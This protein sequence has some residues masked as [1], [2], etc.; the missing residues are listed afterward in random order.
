MG[1]TKL[2]MTPAEEARAIELM[3]Y[4][5]ARRDQE[6]VCMSLARAVARLEA[7]L[8]RTVELLDRA[9]E[10]LIPSGGQ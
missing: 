8:E 10:A 5:V 1:Y 4:D 9:L 7:N 3:R 2:T 6:L